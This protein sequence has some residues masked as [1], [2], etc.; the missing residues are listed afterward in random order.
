MHFQFNTMAPTRACRLERI[1]GATEVRR[2]PGVVG[3]RNYAKPGTVIPGGVM[4]SPL[5]V[6]WGACDDH[7]SMIEVVRQALRA[8]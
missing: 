7:P 4:T 5:D 6:I 8:L 3:Y 1:H 2:I